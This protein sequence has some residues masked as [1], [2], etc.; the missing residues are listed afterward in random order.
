MDKAQ[1]PTK[2]WTPP[3]EVEDYYNSDSSSPSLKQVFLSKIETESSK[4]IIMSILTIGTNNLNEEMATM[5]AMLE[6]RVKE[7][8]EKEARIKL[9]EGKIARL[10]RKLK[11]QP[12]RSLSKSEEK[13]RASVQSEAS[14]EEFHS[15]KGGKLKNGGSRNWMTVEQIQ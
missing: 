1:D 15:K 11:K 9:Q 5:K 13:E 2:L 14:D 10:T 12:A 4:T 8:E 7:S 6:W 3:C